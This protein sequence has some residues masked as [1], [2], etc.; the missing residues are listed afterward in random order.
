[1]RGIA[2]F[3]EVYRS[4][5]AIAV[6]GIQHAHRG[7]RAEWRSPRQ[8]EVHHTSKR[9]QIAAMIDWIAVRLFRRHVLWRA[10]D[11]A[12]TCH[13]GIVDRAGQPKVGQL[14]AFDIVFKQNV[15]G[16]DITM[17]KPQGIRPVEP[18]LLL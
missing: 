16:L 13:A 6:V 4:T 10:S 15:G 3:F 9:E 18:A 8:H 7:F 11:H 1:M 17:N 2:G 5:V 14:D 12:R